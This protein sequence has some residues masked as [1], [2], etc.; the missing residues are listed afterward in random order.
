MVLASNDGCLGT[1]CP[2]RGRVM[3]SN[4]QIKR[5]VERRDK[6]SDRARA[7]D[8]KLMSLVKRRGKYTHELI[9]V[10]KVTQVYK[11]IALCEKKTVSQRC[12]V[13]MRVSAVGDDVP[14]HA[15]IMRRPGLAE[16]S[17]RPTWQ[18]VLFH[19]GWDVVDE[20]SKEKRS[21]LV[22]RKRLKDVVMVARE[23]VAVGV[24]PGDARG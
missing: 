19:D 2:E 16:S 5:W 4:R 17:K 7:I 10:G 15:T 14:R 11:G 18:V 8:E 21:L 23:F 12:T 3:A 13:M 6:I 20:T 22:E 9:L 1:V 24:V